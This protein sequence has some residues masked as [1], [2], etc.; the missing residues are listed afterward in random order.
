[1]LTAPVYH[2]FESLPSTNSYLASIAADAPHGTV[3]SAVGQTAGR[4]QRGN[5]WEAAPGRN[6]TMSILLRPQSIGARNQFMLSEIVSLSIV[7][8][9]KRYIP[10]CEVSIKWPND[11]YVDN[12]KI[13][14]ILI[15]NSLMGNAINYSVAGIGLNV[16]QQR[17]VSDAPNPVSLFQLIGTETPVYEVREALSEE[18]L[19]MMHRYDDTGMFEELHGKYCATLWHREGYYRYRSGVETF[20]ARIEGVSGMGMLT[21]VDRDGNT[22]TYAF[23]EVAAVL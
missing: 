17:F 19:R 14:G 21:L 16:N 3:V 5:S 12:R 10:E 11:V 2:L 4:G 9:L 23:K 13:C 8:V 6:V 18:I 15:E 7:N 1:M 20:D 22:R